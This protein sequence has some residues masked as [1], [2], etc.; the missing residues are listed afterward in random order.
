MVNEV[1]KTR[2]DGTEAPFSSRSLLFAPIVLVM[3]VVPTKDLIEY[4]QKKYYFILCSCCSSE[5]YL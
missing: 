4:E 5:V 2:D 3:P 1:M